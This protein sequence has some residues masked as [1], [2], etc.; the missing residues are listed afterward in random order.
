MRMAVWRLL[1]FVGAAL[2]LVGEPGGTSVLAVSPAAALAPGLRFAAPSPH[3]NPTGLA[4]G[5][6]LVAGRHLNDPNFS[7]TVVLLLGYSQQ[8]AL[9]VIINR[10]TEVSLAE[11]LSEAV[12]PRPPTGQ[13]YIGGPVGRSSMLLLLQSEARAEETEHVFRDVYFSGSLAVL[14]RMIEKKESRF[15]VY[16]G[17]AGWAPGQLDSEVAR[18]DW[19]IVSA[20]VAHIFRTPAEKVWPELIERS[21][22]QWVQ[23]PDDSGTEGENNMNALEEGTELGLDFKKLQSIAAKDLDVVPVVLQHAEKGE[24]LFIGYAND[25]ALR[26]TLRSREAVLWST[27]RNEL[28]RKGATSGDVLDLV[29]VRVNCEQNAL[30]YRVIPRKGGVCHT[31]DQQGQARQ[32]CYYRQLTDSGED[33]EF[34]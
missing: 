27:S 13:V 18:G 5:K 30:L 31:K 8:G 19:H 33:L 9:G 28:W 11:A 10:P 32:T 17:H 22:G 3:L 26:E 34:V 16:A 20:D 1:L 24:V 21:T 25:V 2:F 29:E 14:Q 12:Q 4:K 15:R 7:E 23:L 6:F